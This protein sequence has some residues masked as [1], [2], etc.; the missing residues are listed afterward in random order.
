MKKA[1]RLISVS[2][3]AMMITSSVPLNGT[4]VFAAGGTSSKGLTP[5]ISSDVNGK[6]FTHKEWTGKD[7][8]DAFGK[9]VTGEDVFGINR[10]DHT[11]TVIPYQDTDTAVAAVWDYNA[12]E[13]SVYMKKLTGANET[14]DLTVVQNQSKADPL[15]SAGCMNS[16]YTPSAADGW[17]SVT[18]PKSWTC[19]GF[20]FPIYAN[21]VMPW[22]SAYDY[23]TVP[24]APTNYNPVG[25]YRKKFT[26][27]STM[28]EDNRRIYIQ[29]DGVES[30]YY[31]Y[32]NGKE[33]GYSEDTFSPHRFD[34]TDYLVSGENT[35]A[36]KVH[37]FCDGTWFEGQDMI[38]DGGIFRDVFITSAPLVQI[39]DYTVQTDLDD[40]YV[41]AKLNLSVDVRN[42]STSAMSGWSIDVAAI[43]E[44]G[45]NILGNS[46]IAVDSIGSNKIATFNMSQSVTAPKLWSAEDPNLYALVLT[47]KDGEGNVVETASCQLGFREVS[48][49]SVQVDGSYRRT[50][51]S[52]QPI[53]INGKRLLMKGVNR[54]D[55]DPFNGKAVTQECM[56]E[57]IRLMQE[58]N[59][60]SIRTSHYSND[61]YLYWL[62]NRYGMYVMAETNMEAHALMN[63]NASKGLFYELG[64]DRTKTTF[65]RLKNNP[66]IV[67]WSI[68]NEM[69]YTGDASTS[70][71]L[72]RDM[73]WFFKKNDSTRPVHSE[74][75]GDAMGVDM[76]SN[77]YPGSSSLWS[78]AGAGKMPYVMCEYD[79]AMG[80][81]VGA[82]KEYWD[83]IRS[84]DNMIGGFI[85]DWADQSRAT[86]IPGGT[87]ASEI[88]DAKGATGKCVGT[89]SNGILSGYVAMKSD[90]KFSGLSGSGKAF[91]FE[92]KVKP[93]SAASN[94]VL[95]SKGD[96]QVALKTK[97][98]GTGL[99]FFVYD[100][101]AW[102]AVSCD[103]PSNWVGNWHQVAG[104]YNKG[105]IAIYIDGKLIA[106]DSVKDSINNSTQNVGIGYDGDTGRTFDGQIAYARIYSK[107]LSASEVSGQNSDSP[108]I[109]SSD[110]S[111]LLW[112]DFATAKIGK[113]TSSKFDY[114]SYDEAHKNLYAD[115]S[116]GKYFAYGGD[117]GDKP[118]DNSFCQNG[119]VSPDRD[120]QPE[121]QEVKYQYQNFWFTADSLQIANREVQVYNENN[122]VD[123]SNFTVSYE[124]L[125]NGVVCDSGVVKDAKCA[126]LS[127]AT[128]SVP[129]TMP[130]KIA[131]GDEFYLNIL[132]LAKESKRIFKA[133][134]ELSYEQFEVPA[135]APK[136]PKKISETPATVTESSDGFNISGTDFAFSIS[137][138]T[139]LMKS[140]TYKGQTIISNGPTPNFWR[141]YVEND[142]GNANQK[143][144]DTRWQGAANS[145]KVNSI[146]SSKNENGQPVITANI[147]FPNAG[148]TTENIIYT[149][150]GDG[151]VTV[152]MSVDATKSDMGNFIRV[153][154]T[155]TLPAG[156][157]NVTW[158]GN[159]PVET[160]FDRKTCGRQGIWENTVFG[161]FYPYMKVDD[162]GTMT[163]V[164]WMAVQNKNADAG[165]LIAA[166]NTVEASALHFTPTDL[167]AV[168]HPYELSPRSET[169]LN[170]NYGSMGTGSATCGQSTLEKYRLPSSKVYEWEYTIIPVSGTATTQ[171]LITAAKPYRSTN[172]AIQDQSHNQIVVPVTSEATL[173]EK[174]GK[175]V[176]SGSVSVPSN[177]SLGSAIE[178][179]KSFTVEV[180]V[181]P[182]GN[183]DFNMFAG[184]GDNGFALR[185]RNGY[186][187]F[188]IYAGGQ[189]RS[190][191]YAMST[192]ASSGWIGKEHQVAG[193]Y[194]AESNMLRV[195]ADGKMLAEKAVGTTS[196]VA[197]TNY[198][199][200]IGACP[201]TGRSSQAEFSTVRVYNK[202]LNE[203]E[204]KTQNTASPT[205]KADSSV[206]ELWIDFS[207]EIEPEIIDDSELTVTLRG[208]VNCD[209]TVTVSDAI[210]MS[211]LVNQDTTCD[212]SDQ[213]K[214]N[215]EMDD[216]NAFTALD[217]TQILRIVARLDQ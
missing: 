38:Y 204:L 172:T 203:S 168:N 47:L 118:N 111:V 27:D 1:K 208:D 195:Y 170:I 185:T 200:T 56:E 54:H 36:V 138:S 211:R 145:I 3:A 187:D 143:L 130:S 48:F 127:K 50:T 159:G 129:Y 108:A 202:A 98:Q 22:Q 24:E 177:N 190:L 180:N 178:G 78:K 214:L 43:D 139:G 123:L 117:W 156:F 136:Y 32:I 198:N 94:S 71:G 158:Y 46:S 212:V 96:H 146:Q 86:P 210:L 55:T 73:I 107:A 13:D 30:A 84:A 148:G 215:G 201:D 12:R 40:N 63:D 141:C 15:I 163:D 175:T 44:N 29:F 95:I 79:H 49:T 142:A 207:A 132:V 5:A 28:L 77:M 154:S 70:N 26:L 197:K 45:K 183:P 176:M 153:G 188:F 19:Q 64:M 165:V 151:Q 193:V 113:A 6:K 25:L 41:N 10:E 160:M 58:N 11:V 137:K 99:E 59:I 140:Y 82:L 18:L 217:I 115:L 174:N 152:N 97:S 23:V 34:I 114:Y 109:S 196:G 75:Q 57:D 100:G 53:K 80:N 169:Y 191:E 9:N 112:M 150:N 65:E 206:V 20:D 171:N 184:K 17:K 83:P 167:G 67:M 60:N 103:L 157:E 209:G 116:G 72:F 194:D 76:A 61:S 120:P 42:L 110:A 37:K 102:N 126:P 74:G 4:T 186:L 162:C 39:Y 16:N 87:S 21:V 104:V 106:E 125:R 147:T 182:T 149:I 144:F 2:A 8:T 124:L 192:D 134:V 121:L 81:S 68:G 133:G 69:V 91:T 213:G 85:W 101:S 89:V 166:T 35:L 179:N 7:Y 31:V 93:V 62:C 128:I 122:F 155:L 173:K 189:W 199:L 119:L 105:A 52:F 161:M 181:T 216:D 90:S 66:A 164:K 131:A 92:A 88:T 135:A 33:V 51:T 14:W 205:Y